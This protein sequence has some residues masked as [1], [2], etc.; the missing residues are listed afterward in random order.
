MCLRLSMWSGPRNVSTALMYSFRERSDTVVFDEPLYGHYLK[1]SGAD[2]PG[3]DEVMATLDTDGERVVRDVLLAPCEKPIRFY[4]N[5][6]HHLLGLERTFLSSLTNILLTRDPR[7]MLPSL[8]QQIPNPILRDTGLKEQV[9]ILEIILQR[10][11]TP[12]VV[13]S[14][15]LLFNP[16]GVLEEVCK[17]LSIPFEESMLFWTAGAKPEDGVWAKYWYHNVHTSTSFGKYETKK[18]VF[19]R[20]LEN[21]LR[22]SLPLYERLY[23]YAIS[24]RAN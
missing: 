16:R 24:P 20:H 6:A 9:E 2:H 18:G 14:R 21:L 19:P 3:K 11:Q 23:T 13:D 15:E 17:R 4:K 7:D 8:A 10:G 12:V 5:M 22:E 1:A